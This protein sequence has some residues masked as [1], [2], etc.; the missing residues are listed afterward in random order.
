MATIQPRVQVC[1]DA[2]TKAI[3]ENAA[4]A[5]GIS[6]SRIIANICGDAAPTILGLTK[7]LESVKVD[8]SPAKYL[9][10]AKGITVEARQTILNASS[11]LDGVQLDLEAEIAKSKG[12]DKVRAPVGTRAKPKGVSKA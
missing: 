5:M 6:T 4:K 9:D 8:P 1:L 3:Y 12:Q 10:M 11:T 7:M 2:E